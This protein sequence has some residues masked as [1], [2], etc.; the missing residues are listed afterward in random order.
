MANFT[1]SKIMFRIEPG[2]R[3]DV[4]MGFLTA[5]IEGSRHE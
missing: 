4:F 2:I 1:S 3:P 5:A